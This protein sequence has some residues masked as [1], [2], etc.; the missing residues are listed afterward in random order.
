MPFYD[1]ELILLRGHYSRY[2]LSVLKRIP[3]MENS[4]DQ[5]ETLRSATCSATWLGYVFRHTRVNL[6]FNL[7]SKTDSV[8]TEP[9]IV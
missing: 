8:L 3:V 7:A 4:A 9:V 6:I 2:E 5:I 1:I